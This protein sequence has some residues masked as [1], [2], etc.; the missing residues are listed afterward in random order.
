[1]LQD[2]VEQ[3]SVIAI[4]ADGYDASGGCDA[5]THDTKKAQLPNNNSDDDTPSAAAAPTSFSLF[6]MLDAQKGGFNLPPR[7][8]AYQIIEAYERE[9][10]QRKSSN[11]TNNIQTTHIDSKS[12]T[13]TTLFET[14]KY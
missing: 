2:A 11:S 3:C 4:I 7:V 1:M 13:S 10:K 9:G 14:I 5:M 6:D 12:T 8:M